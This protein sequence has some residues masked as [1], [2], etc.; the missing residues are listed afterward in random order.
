MLIQ[1]TKKLLDELKMKPEP[2]AEG[3]PQNPLLAWHANLIM[4]DRKKAVALVNDK[5][6]Y[7]VILYGLKAKDFKKLDELIPQAIR[8]VLLEEGISEGIIDNY[9]TQSGSPVFTKT[10]DRTSVAR[11]NTSIDSILHMTDYLNDDSL[12]Q[13]QLCMKVNTFMVGDG[14][15][16]YYDPNEVMYEDLEAFA[17]EPVFHLKAAVL[18]IALQLPPHSIWRKLV[19]PLH[20]SF[21]EL[22]QAIQIA[23]DWSDRHLYEFNVYEGNPQNQEQPGK[24]LVN[25]V[26]DDWE[27]E[28]VLADPDK[29]FARKVYLQDYLTNTISYIYDFGDYW[30]HDIKV[31][32]IIDSYDKNYPTCIEAEGLVP[33]EDIGGVPGYEAFLGILQDPQHPDYLKMK[34]LE[35]MSL[36]SL[37]DLNKMNRRMKNRW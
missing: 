4:I 6:R 26:G 29:Q 22:H 17:G 14:K 23:F 35:T 2:H 16:D 18:K 5:N 1:C 20:T 8:E 7:M 33:P 10:K 25:F 36:A 21:H 13:K 19:V 12:V 34:V 9:L 11:M 24:F 15:G 3:Y 28:E 30:E 32:A 31:E 27:Y 37:L